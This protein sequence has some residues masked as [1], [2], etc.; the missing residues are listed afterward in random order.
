MKY[1]YNV[2]K[3][4]LH[5]NDTPFNK[6]PGQTMTT[7]ISAVKDHR[8]QQTYLEQHEGCVMVLRE[9]FGTDNKPTGELEKLYR[10]PDSFIRFAEFDEKTV[11]TP[12][13]TEPKQPLIQHKK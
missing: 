4:R 3:I 5:S 8:G 1:P 6:L 2:N 12:P 10:I 13:A 7:E 9:V 11:Q